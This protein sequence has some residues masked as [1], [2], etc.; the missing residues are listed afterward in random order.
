[1]IIIQFISG[2]TKWIFFI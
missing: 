2:Q 1:M